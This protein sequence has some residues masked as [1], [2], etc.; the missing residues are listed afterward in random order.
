[1]SSIRRFKLGNHDTGYG[2]E[3]SLNFVGSATTTIELESEP[4][5][6]RRNNSRDLRRF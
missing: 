6:K 1:M 3:L 4:V 5:P 2:Y